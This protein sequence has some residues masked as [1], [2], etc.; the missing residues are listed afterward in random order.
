MLIEQ[1]LACAELMH[2][3][4][5][6]ADVEHRMAIRLSM[7]HHVMPHIVSNSRVQGAGR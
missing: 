2:L 7:I 1:G 6:A 4:R 3:D 5:H